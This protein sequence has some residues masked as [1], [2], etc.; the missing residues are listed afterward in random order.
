MV[1]VGR[2]EIGVFNVDGEFYALPNVCPHQFGPLLRRRGQRHDACSAATDWRFEWVRE[3][4][5]ITCPWHGMEFDI[6]TGRCLAS[7]KVRL[8]QYVVTVEAGQV[9]VTI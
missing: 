1:Q 6:T 3:G 4:E 9:T 2:V 7:A 5:I 8:R